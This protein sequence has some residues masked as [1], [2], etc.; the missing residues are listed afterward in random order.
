[1][2]KA[3]KK[4][5]VK[6]SKSQ[7]VKKSKAGKIIKKPKIKSKAKK[8]PASKKAKAAKPQG[9]E[10]SLEKVGEV[11]HYFPHV[12]AAAVKLFQFLALTKYVHS[13]L[14]MMG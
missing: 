6:V 7:K 3:K 4:K 14:S 2:V 10:A 11:T 1:M 8:I 5:S 13:F 12:N 9:P